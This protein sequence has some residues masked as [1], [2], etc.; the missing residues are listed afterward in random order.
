[1]AL[2]N[3]IDF[4]FLLLIVSI[5]NIIF[6]RW[7]KLF[8][9]ILIWWW[10]QLLQWVLFGC[11]KPHMI[12]N[13]LLPFNGQR[14]GMLSILQF[15]GH[16]HLAENSRILNARRVPVELHC[17]KWLNYNRIPF[18][19]YSK[20]FQKALTLR[21]R[22]KLLWFVLYYLYHILSARSYKLCLYTINTNWR[23]SFDSLSV[24]KPN[25]SSL[26][27]YEVPNKWEIA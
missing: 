7:K 4:V 1:M 23:F 11:H 2:D 12:V 19:K 9:F 27:F 6:I 16:S 13:V 20:R 21:L 24:H 8:P 14:P 3:E 22:H 25:K 17:Y 5:M 15:D 18:T 26:C 10:N